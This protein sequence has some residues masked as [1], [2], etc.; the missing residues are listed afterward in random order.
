[1]EKLL[2]DDPQVFIEH[3][4]VFR[5]WLNQSRE[6][7]LQKYLT[8]EAL[9]YLHRCVQHSSFSL[10]LCYLTWFHITNLASLIPA[11]CWR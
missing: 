11:L 1:M 5:L 8:H 10:C 3:C 4:H 7:L 9:R 2:V 6:I